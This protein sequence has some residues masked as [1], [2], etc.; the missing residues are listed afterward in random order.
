MRTA[1]ANCLFSED[2][3]NSVVLFFFPNA[4]LPP[5]VLQA[6]IA[7]RSVQQASC[8]SNCHLGTSGIFRFAVPR[9]RVASV[10]CSFAKRQFIQV[11]L[12][13]HS[14]FFVLF[15]TKAGLSHLAGQDIKNREGCMLLL[16]M[17]VVPRGQGGKSKPKNADREPKCH[18]PPCLQFPPL[19]KI[20]CRTAL[21]GSHGPKS[22]L[23]SPVHTNHN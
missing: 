18:I 10:T 23:S 13:I 16:Y 11:P 12:E 1:G 9:L 15:F 8:K 6:L 21:R 3:S 4:T 19:E 14:F 5:G 20:G 17:Q 2:L 22:A 7:H